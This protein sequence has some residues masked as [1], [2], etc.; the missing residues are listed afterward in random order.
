MEPAT[1]YRRARGRV[2]NESSIDMIILTL[3]VLGLAFGS[4]ANVYFYRLPDNLSLFKPN[5]F[6]PHCRHSIAYRDNI[7]VIS[8][9][10]LGGKCR[11]CH[12]PISWQYPVVE[13]LCGLLFMAVA[14]KF[15]TYPISYLAVFLLFAFVL[16]LIAGIDLITYFK[17]DRQYGII[18]DHLL[19]ILVAASIAFSPLNPYLDQRWWMCWVSGMGMAAFMLSMRWIFQRILKQEALGLGDVKLLTVIAS[20][21]GWQGGITAL[22]AASVLGTLVSLGLMAMKKVQ[23]RSAVPFGPFIALGA[24]FVLFLF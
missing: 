7:P 16:F 19:W 22:I 24:L 21:L 11:Y 5:S 1:T 9:L 2:K 4:F 13:L 8:Y 12:T 18:P 10:L 23:L 17:N 3:A 6:C 20:F 15:R 14:V